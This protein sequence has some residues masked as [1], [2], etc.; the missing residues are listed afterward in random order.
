LNNLRLPQRSVGVLL[1]SS[2]YDRQLDTEE[3]RSSRNKVTRLTF[4]ID[5]AQYYRINKMLLKSIFIFNF[6]II[7]CPV[8][9]I[10]LFKRVLVWQRL[11]YFQYISLNDYF[12]WDVLR[13]STYC[14]LLKNL[15]NIS[16]TSGKIIYLFLLQSEHWSWYIPLLKYLSWIAGIGFKK[17]SLV[18]LILYATF[19]SVLLKVLVT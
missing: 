1:Y 9:N 19:R 13:S 6:I 10:I 17:C 5:V 18:F 8:I 16:C 15:D 14:F 7:F 12:K 11:W 2:T 4:L 3:L